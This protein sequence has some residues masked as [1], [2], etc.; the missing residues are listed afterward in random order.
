MSTDHLRTW[1]FAWVHKAV[2][3]NSKCLARDLSPH[4][5]G[6]YLGV[7]QTK[8]TLAQSDLGWFDGVV[9]G[10]LS[11]HASGIHGGGQ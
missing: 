11:F 2:S 8:L 5:A 7:N 1:W 3:G 6:R 10:S 4:F 9:E